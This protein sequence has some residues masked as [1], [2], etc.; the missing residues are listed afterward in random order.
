MPEAK[1]ET[2]R[3]DHL[4]KALFVEQECS[5]HDSPCLESLDW[6]QCYRETEPHPHAH[7]ELPRGE[8]S[9]QTAMTGERASVISCVTPWY[10]LPVHRVQPECPASCTGYSSLSTAQPHS[11]ISRAHKLTVCDRH[12]TNR[13]VGYFFRGFLF[14]ELTFLVYLFQ[15]TATMG[16][17]SNM[18]R[19]LCVQLC[20]N[21][22]PIPIHNISICAPPPPPY[23]FK[24]K[25]LA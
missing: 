22:C 8:R 13:Q 5:V 20:W 24:C 23:L 10:A 7:T 19:K 11:S 4:Y 9:P 14:P 1:S 25:E 12:T 17:L 3:F 15:I 16:F 6:I 21:R 18:R 2:W